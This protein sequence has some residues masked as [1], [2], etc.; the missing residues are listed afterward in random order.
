MTFYGFQIVFI[1]IQASLFAYFVL[2]ASV[3]VMVTFPDRRTRTLAAFEQILVLLLGAL[4]R[5]LR[6]VTVDLNETLRQASRRAANGLRWVRGHRAL[7]SVALLAVL[8]PS[9]AVLA[10]RGPTLFDLIDHSSATDRQIARLLEGEQLTPPLPLPPE[11]FT[12]REAEQIWPDIATASRDWDLLDP[13][14]AQRLLVVFKLMKERHGYEMVLIEGHRSPQRQEQ[15]LAQGSHMTQARANM[16]YHQHGLAADCAFLMEGRIAISERD[17][18]VM[19][20]YQLYGELAEQVGLTWG[21]GWRMQDYG[22]VELRRPSV[23]G[24][25]VS[26]VTAGDTADLPKLN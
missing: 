18:L 9:L 22:H 11:V 21:G 8:A 17:P 6:G 20:G 23:L 4:S 3:V 10:M 5:L 25:V 24:N 26:H 12:T 2:V 15:L 1:V 13:L 19:R 16:S 14:F 7:V